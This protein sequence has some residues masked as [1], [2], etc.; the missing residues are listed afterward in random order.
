MCAVQPECMLPQR[1]AYRW[2]WMLLLRP[3]LGKHWCRLQ[4]SWMAA[5]G[6]LS[7]RNS[8]QRTCEVMMMQHAP[9]SFAHLRAL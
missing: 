3:A 2:P 5:D 9:D 1:A 7:L 8:K 4:I 6:P